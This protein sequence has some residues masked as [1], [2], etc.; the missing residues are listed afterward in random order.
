MSTKKFTR[1]LNRR[2]APLKSRHSFARFAVV[3]TRLRT[4]ATTRIA[5]PNARKKV[6]LKLVPVKIVG[7]NFLQQSAVPKNFALSLVIT[8]TVDGMK[9][10]NALFVARN[11]KFTLRAKKYTAQANV[12]LQ[13]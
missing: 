5:P 2:V 13:P 12:S 3:D 1:Q 9:L 11:L 8:N 10:K 6:N 7:M 4:G